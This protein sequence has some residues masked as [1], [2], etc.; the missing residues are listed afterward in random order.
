MLAEI[1]K[2][3]SRSVV[4]PVTVL[5]MLLEHIECSYKELVTNTC[6]SSL[7]LTSGVG[8]HYAFLRLNIII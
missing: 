7:S 3:I 1:K 4:Y 8:G 2:P 6:T 5:G